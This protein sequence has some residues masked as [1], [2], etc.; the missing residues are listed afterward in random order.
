MLIIRLHFF[1]IAE[2]FRGL[3]RIFPI[4]D[5]RNE[6]GTSMPLTLTRG[7]CAFEIRPGNIGNG[8]RALVCHS[9]IHLA[10]L[11]K[12]PGDE[13]RQGTKRDTDISKI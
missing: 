6:L 1:L 12:Y 9:I 3:E 2:V 11:Y 8:F 4:V 7:N 13:A 10:Y 5:L